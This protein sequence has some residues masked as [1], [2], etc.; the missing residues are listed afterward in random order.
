M[1]SKAEE[2][3]QFDKFVASTEEDGYLRN[4]FGS[5]KLRAWVA[6]QID[7]DHGVSLAEELQV[8]DTTIVSLQA[9]LKLLQDMLASKEDAID[10]LMEALARQNRTNDDLKQQRSDMINKYESR[11][12]HLESRAYQAELEY[13][14]LKN[15]LSVVGQALKGA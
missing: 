15:A 8:R 4:I 10:G 2:L 12:S 5:R 6:D 13:D 11:I 3:A 1:L 14:R 9:Q 7:M